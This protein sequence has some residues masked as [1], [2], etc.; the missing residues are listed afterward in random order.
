MTEKGKGAPS[1]LTARTTKRFVGA[2]SGWCRRLERREEEP[3][4]PGLD[5]RRSLSHINS[6]IDAIELVGANP[7]RRHS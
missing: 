2:S 3:L 1:R 5:D 7:G 6:N 4:V